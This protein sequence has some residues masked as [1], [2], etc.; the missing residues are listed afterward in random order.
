MG[1]CATAFRT[2]ASR[3][4][5]QQLEQCR[6]QV[7]SLQTCYHL[8]HILCYFFRKLR[9][10][11]VLW[12]QLPLTRSL[13]QPDG[14]P[15]PYQVFQ[16]QCESCSWQT[17]S[18]IRCPNTGQSTTNIDFAFIL[19]QCGVVFLFF[20]FHINQYRFKNPGAPFPPPFKVSFRVLRH[21]QLHFTR[22]RLRKLAPRERFI[23][24]LYSVSL[25]ISIF[26]HRVRHSQALGI[27][28]HYPNSFSRTIK[29]M[30]SFYFH[31]N[32]LQ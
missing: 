12:N 13:L 18:I 2:T 25:T 10:C 17:L 5:L 9:F 31:Y 7:L 19:H 3:M 23:S 1:L 32:F 27:I 11:G 20:E 14:Q 30:S 6:I 8:D 21:F 29:N 4:R 28:K 22:K 16:S 26:W 15:K 24:N